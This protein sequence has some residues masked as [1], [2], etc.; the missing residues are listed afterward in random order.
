[1]ESVSERR[2]VY[3]SR[4]RRSWNSFLQYLKMHKPL[5]SVQTCTGA[6]AV[7]FI[8]YL[9]RFGKTK[10]HTT[11]CPSFGKP[12]PNSSSSSSHHC[13][14]PSRQGWWSLET[15]V[16]RLRSA[17]KEF[18]LIHRPNPNPNPFSSTHIL[19]YMKE[20]RE[21]LERSKGVCF[22][23]KRRRRRRKTKTP[24]LEEVKDQ[25][26]GHSQDL[27]T[28]NSQSNDPLEL[29]STTT[30]TRYEERKQQAWKSFERYLRTEKPSLMLEHCTCA[31]VIQ[32]L[33]YLDQFGKT[34][35]HL[36]DCIYF[37]VPTAF[38]LCG[39][40]FKQSWS[41][42]DTL[43][44]RLRAAYREHLGRYVDSNPFGLMEVRDYLKDVK[45]EQENARGVICK[46]SKQGSKNHSKQN[47]IS[48]YRSND[49]EAQADP[50]FAKKRKLIH[51]EDA[52]IDIGIS[53]FGLSK[54]SSDEALNFS[55]NQQ[56]LV[57]QPVNEPIWRMVKDFDILVDEI[58]NN[59]LAMRGVVD[60]FEV[61]IFSSLKLQV[62]H[63][64]IE[65]KHY[66]WGVFI[67]NSASSA[68][69]IEDVPLL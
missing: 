61:L 53:D 26:G 66:L 50:T 38:V 3:E 8:K 59:D 2:S 41:N 9:D 7:D 43:V 22:V 51:K 65:G 40:P 15:L 14:C 10:L 57:T 44:E 56:N 54:V 67:G 28:L 68:I 33:Q 5:L 27:I 47:K 1:M 30:P 29:D 19:H 62:E 49:V 17:Y 31:D 34:K 25:V 16:E 18:V 6:D 46:R 69:Q 12:N 21:E 52:N 35:V 11:D 4:K 32:F 63:Q 13:R 36:S 45:K 48:I 58:T 55:V 39:C 37:G 64:K 24:E 42:L 60:D 23:D 20:F